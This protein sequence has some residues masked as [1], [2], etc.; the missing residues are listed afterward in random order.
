[1]NQFNHISSAQL[2]VRPIA[3][4]FN[5]GQILKIELTLRVTDLCIFGPVIRVFIRHQGAENYLL[6]S[7]THQGGI[8]LPW[9]PRGEFTFSYAWP[10]SLPNGKYE[11]GIAWGTVNELRPPDMLKS[12]SIIEISNP[13]QLLLGTWQVASDT[14][15]KLSQLSWHKGM[16]N[17]FHRHFCHAAE[18]IAELCLNNSEKLRGR[19]LD[20]GAGE[21]ITDLSLVLRYQPEEL[22]A[23]DIVDYIK[24]LPRVAQENGLPLEKLPDNFT[25]LQQ[26]CE[27]LPYP[28]ASFDLVLSWGS[29]EHIKGGY[30][31]ALDEVYRVLR[32]GGLFFVAP[33]LYYSAFGSHLG[34]FSDIPHLHLRIPEDK[35]KELVMTTKPNIMDRSGFDVS[36]EDYWRFYKELNRIHVAGFEN[37]LRGYGYTMVRGVIRT[38]DVVEYD[39]A[40]QPYSLI[41][42]AVEEPYFTVQKPETKTQ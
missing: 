36:N 22:V 10:I 18:V 29:L 4:S 32:P 41:D 38:S 42:L 1:M 20:I 15:S 5:G 17:W 16:S 34:E 25:F 30:R 7:D 35:L 13:C 3:E 33:G 19:V 40:L 26:S 12:F 21:G 31:K 9:L 39:D 6:G 37:E 2:D 11:L 27:S 8:F 23:V 28:D 14:Q 24:E